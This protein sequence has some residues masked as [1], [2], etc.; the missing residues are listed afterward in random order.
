MMPI[1]TGMEDQ[2]PRENLLDHEVKV[3]AA[4]VA[5]IRDKQLRT[6]VSV[7]LREIINNY[8]KRRPLSNEEWRKLTNPR[9]NKG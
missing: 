5:I 6:S 8:R 3:L 9:I 1:A 7:K 2:M 4:A